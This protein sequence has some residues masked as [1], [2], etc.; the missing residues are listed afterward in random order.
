MP[1]AFRLPN[2]LA[3]CV[4]LSPDSWELR[5]GELLVPLNGHEVERLRSILRV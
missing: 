3:E 1:E 5:V 4:P 2:S